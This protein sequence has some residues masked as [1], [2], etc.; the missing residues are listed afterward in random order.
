MFRYS[1]FIILSILMLCMMSA[2]PLFAQQEIRFGVLAKRGVEKAYQ[3]WGPTADYLS[4]KLSVNCVLVPLKFVEIEPALK[5]H[6]IHFLLANSAFYARYQEKYNLKAVTTMINR[7]G[8][9]A[10]DT[11]GGVLFARNNSP[12]NTV[13]D[14]RGKRM[15]CVKYSSFGGAQM[16]WRMMLEQ[17]VDPKKDCT[18]FTEG[19]THDNVV[20]AVKAGKAD[21]GTV[22]SDTLE[23]MSAEGKIQMSDFKIINQFH[24]SYPF[25]HSTQLYPEWP[26]AACSQTD[27]KLARKVAKAL[28]LLS[29]THEAMAASKVYKWTYPAN[30]AEVK[31]CLRVIG[32][33]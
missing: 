24:D 2:A 25:V 27:S 29:F 23:R 22:R 5:K 9:I 8:D 16:V 17:G 28:V 10:L 31:A 15:M 13:A 6:E 3:Q 7:K 33:E 1:R 12:I 21:V 30:Y 19:G 26:V 18:A 14:I 4:K 11:F 32:I 20:L